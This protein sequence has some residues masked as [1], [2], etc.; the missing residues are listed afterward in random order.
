M[1]KK[2]RVS[3]CGD[4]SGWSCL[5][6]N[7]S[8]PSAGWYPWRWYSEYKSHGQV[9]GWCHGIDPRNT[10]RMHQSPY[11]RRW[12]RGSALIPARL[13]VSLWTGRFCSRKGWWACAWTTL[14]LPG[15]RRASW[16]RAFDSNQLLEKTQDQAPKKE[17]RTY[18]TLV[19]N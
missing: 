4:S 7:P 6:R 10:G 14:H 19:L 3:R 9:S 8:S 15:T 1:R 18:S 17:S 5:V 13:P 12:N 2:S 16:L 11:S